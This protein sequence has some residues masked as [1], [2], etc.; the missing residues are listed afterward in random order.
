M[1]YWRK[2][3]NKISTLTTKTKTEIETKIETEIETD[4]KDEIKCIRKPNFTNI[5]KGNFELLKD[6]VNGKLT[7]KSYS[8]V[9]NI[10]TKYNK[11]DPTLNNKRVCKTP[12]AKWY[13]KGYTNKIR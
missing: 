9:A 12:L 4:N 3:K 11:I 2:K 1:L 5:I 8:N 10:Y 13:V 7:V 6:I